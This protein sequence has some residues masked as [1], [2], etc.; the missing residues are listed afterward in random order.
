M[1]SFWKIIEPLEDINYFD[2]PSCEFG[3]DG[4]TS[5]GVTVIAQD[6][7][8]A[9]TGAYSIKSSNV[10]SSPD[11]LYVATVAIPTGT[12]LYF[13][14]R[15]KGVVGETYDLIVYNTF[16]GSV[17]AE[18]AFVATGEWDEFELAFS[19]TNANPTYRIRGDAQSASPFYSDGIE[20]TVENDGTYIDGDQIDC[21]WDG[22]EHS[23]GSR[24]SALVRGGGKVIDIEDTY[25]CVEAENGTGERPGDYQ[26]QDQPDI[27]GTETTGLKILRRP[28]SLGL[29]FNG[30]SWTDLRQKRNKLMQIVSP[31]LVPFINDAPQR[32]RFQNVGTART[33]QID[34]HYNGGLEFA[35]GVGSGFVESTTMQLLSNDKPYFYQLPQSGAVL[36]VNDTLSLDMVAGRENGV[37]SN[38]GVTSF[39]GLGTVATVAIGSDGL[40]YFGGD[41]TN[42]NGIANADYLFS[43][44]P[45][46]GTVTA[47][48]SGIDNTVSVILPLIS[49]QLLIGG[50]FT[51]AD[52]DAANAYVFLYDPATAT[53]TAASSAKLNNAVVGADQDPS[54]GDIIVTGWFTQDDTPTTLNRIA[55]L[56]SGGTYQALGASPGIDGNGQAVG[57][58]S[59]GQIIVGGVHTEQLSALDAGGSDFYEVG[60]S[61]GLNGDVYTIFVDNDADEVLVG[62]AFTTMDGEDAKRLIRLGTVS[63][64]YVQWGQVGGGVSD[65]QVR[66]IAK[67]PDGSYRI[68]GTYDNV[69]DLAACDSIT[70]LSGDTWLR[71]DLTPD[72]FTNYSAFGV[73]IAKNGDEYYGFEDLTAATGTQAAAITTITLPRGCSETFPQLKLKKGADGDA[74]KAWKLVSI[75]NIS[76]NQRLTFDSL[77]INDDELITIDCAAG[78]LISNSGRNLD[79]YLVSG[80]VRTFFLRDGE[81]RLVIYAVDGSDVDLDAVA[82]YN[83]NF[84]GVDAAE[85]DGS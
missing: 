77:E 25:A 71:N 50:F 60:N 76:T 42:V 7:S 79:G 20:V 65:G 67:A 55:R 63:S 68:T 2:N 53:A 27:P 45:R 66:G 48:V 38:I 17:A 8:E 69:D 62:G 84:W 44:N 18:A 39:S 34:A 82:H 26:E 9:W 83:V 47:V 46:S 80:D 54:T 14:A 57:V 41:F 52:S 74:D 4:F 33:L 5:S 56:P 36:D 37:W 23:S 31:K 40:V 51:T 43:Y 72:P 10:T 35:Q 75:E 73:A 24:R 12:A 70:R 78:K 81:N 3:I 13:R 11:W 29:L 59:D 61:T 6:S 22:A 15:V 58:R 28:W 85:D 1:T 49:G 64:G 21:L 30:D 32:V 19:A 16:P